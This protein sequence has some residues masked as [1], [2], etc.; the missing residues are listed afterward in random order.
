MSVEMEVARQIRALRFLDLDRLSQALG[1]LPTPTKFISSKNIPQKIHWCSEQELLDAL[2]DIFERFPGDEDFGLWSSVTDAIE[3]FEEEKIRTRLLL[4]LKR[5]PMWKTA[6]LAVQYCTKEQL[7]VILQYCISFRLQPG[8]GKRVDMGH[9]IHI[10][11][12]GF[13][14]ASTS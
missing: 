3:L 13:L 5:Q 2:F 14:S 12:E 11:E 4:S 10:L 8:N 7:E 9:V 6:E 1:R